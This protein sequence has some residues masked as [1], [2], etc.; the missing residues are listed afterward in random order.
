MNLV[1]A[2]EIG[3]SSPGFRCATLTMVPTCLDRGSLKG[4]MLGMQDCLRANGL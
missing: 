3:C 2:G 4:V 1:R